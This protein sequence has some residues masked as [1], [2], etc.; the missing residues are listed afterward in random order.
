MNITAID[1]TGEQTTRSI[2]L[3]VWTPVEVQNKGA[4][5]TVRSFD[6]VPVSGCIPGGDIGRDVSYAE[7]TSE[8]RSRTFRISAS[9]TGE[10]NGGI[11]AGIGSPATGMIGAN[12]GMR[13]SATFG[14]GVDDSVSSS[15]SKDLRISGKLLPGEFGAFY[16][17]TLQ[18]ERTAELIG[19]GACGGSQVVGQAIITTSSLPP[20]S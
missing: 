20:H 10:V 2:K 15:E 18:L 7:S 13:L 5:R 11:N 14:F 19:H 1:S 4:V 8:T 6:P 3:R 12:F 17:Q 9:A 16:R